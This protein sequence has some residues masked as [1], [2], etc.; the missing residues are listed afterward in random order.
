M[1]KVEM[2]VNGRKALVDAD[3]VK[4]IIRKQL[5]VA[6]VKELDAQYRAEADPICKKL[7]AD[8]I[9]DKFAEMKR[10]RIR[11]NVQFV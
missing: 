6:R 10:L 8:A 1:Q 11:Q 3:Q 7:I 9:A 5:I 4:K 2:L